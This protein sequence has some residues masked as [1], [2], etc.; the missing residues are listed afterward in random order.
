MGIIWTIIIGFVAGVIAKFVMPGDN[1]PSGFIMTTLLGVVGAFVATYLG[2]AL[3]SGRRLAQSSFWRS[4]VLS[5]NAL[6]ATLPPN[7]RKIMSKSTPSLLALLGLVAFAGYQNRGRIS[8]MLSDAGRAAAPG[9]RT[10][11]APG[12]APEAGGFLESLGD[13]FRSGLGGN[14]LSTAFGDLL[15]R[16]KTA[17]LGT[18]AESW[19]S[20]EANHPIRVDEL[21]AAIGP[22][23]LDELGLKTGLSRQELL[24][25]L[26][27]ALPEVVNRLTPH[28]RLP[29]DEEA[30]TLA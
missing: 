26:N 25:R 6:D 4:G 30:Q 2:Q 7:R 23:T 3:G 8:D 24:L 19:V 15:T 29:T 1:E 11:A 28:G 13:S 14:G 21:E 12:T 27:V 5:A 16:F 10:D 22:E 18:T 9:A 20:T 17:G